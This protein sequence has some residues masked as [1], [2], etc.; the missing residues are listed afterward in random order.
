MLGQRVIAVRV[1]GE[2]EQLIAQNPAGLELQPGQ[3]LE[4][5]SLRASLHRLYATGRYADITAEAVPVA[6]G[7]RI[8][9]RVRDN[10]FVGSVRVEGLREP[11][12]DAQA[13]G[14]LRLSLGETFRQRDLDRG[15]ARLVQLLR[16][17]G[18]YGAVFNPVLA[19]RPE[20]HLVD[21]TVKVETG[22]RARLGPVGASSTPS[23]PASELIHASRLKPGQFLTA[24]RLERGAERARKWLF[25]R[26]FYA[27]R[28]AARAG[29]L[30]AERNMVPV[31]LEITAGSTVKLEVVGVKLSSGKL[32]QLVPVF[33]EGSVDEDLL[34]EGRRN[35]R[36]YYE[37]R[38]Y[39][40]CDVQY[41]ST[42]NP[43]TGA[44]VITYTVTPGARRR[45]VA[46]EF[47]GNKYF[48]DDLLRSQLT[49]HPAEV[50]RSAIFSRRLLQQNE[51]ALRA[52]YVSNGFGSAKVQAEAVEN[53]RGHPEE[54]LARFRIEEGAQTT[55]E[56]LEIA[57][58]SAIA[59]TTLLGVVGS[60]PG[61]PF[62][63]ANV[64]SDRDNILALYLDEGLPETRFESRAFPGSGPGHVRL[65]YEISEG[66]RITVA[67]VLVGGNEHTRM[68]VIRRRI[69]LK[70]EEPLREG[71]VIST[72]RDLYNLGIFSH[73]AVAQ[74]NPQGSETDKT[75]LVNVQEGKRFTVGY[76]AGLE[77][78]PLNNTND[79]TSTT[80]DFAPRG[81]LELTWANFLGRA[82]TVQLR[83]RASTLQGRALLE[84]S[85]PQ[86]LNHR[87]WNLQL[88][89]FADKTRDVRTFTS[90]RYEGSLQLEHRLS[91]ITTLLYR[92]TFRRVLTSDLR[93]AP[94]EIPL[95]SQPTQISGP[96][97]AWVR[98]LR[99]NPANPSRGR[100]Y[101]VDVGL[102]P[103]SLDSTASFLRVFLQN[104]S[105][106]PL[107]HHLVFARSTRF[108]METPFG[109]SL[110]TDIPLAERF[111]AGGG[112]SL[113]GFGLNQ[114]GPRDTTTGFPVGGLTLMTFN[115]ELRFPLRLPYTTAAVT[116]ALFYDA[117]NVYTS[118]RTISLRTTPPPG[119]LNW[120][121][122]SIGFGVHYPTP[123]GPIRIDFGYLL[124]A[125][126][127]QFC[128]NTSA[129][130][131]SVGNPV[132]LGRQRRFQFFLTFGA[133]F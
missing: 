53:Y 74:E 1:V 63:D 130:C 67:Q 85:A 113:R 22:H 47:T 117:G 60:R 11:P 54:L 92:Y 38:G 88:I 107:G 30:D 68:D 13:I 82:Q 48:K 110:S 31:M 119:D 97:V 40:D 123:V 125:P 109:S 27:A 75:M 80:L 69:V 72:Q 16:E 51:D 46:V 15:L 59:T 28:V 21:V 70:P 91:P 3:A 115:Q 83:A 62:S 50:F 26:G 44:R 81:L 8:D 120:L 126:Q 118:L 12:S 73:V 131:P 116:G 128:S 24:A 36:D 122:H 108:G 42:S 33:Q 103:R 20:T 29:D 71:D 10:F 18:F 106:T 98:D 37:R 61:Q 65:A 101:T 127:F 23:F 99:D 14:S 56:S 4:R 19:R 77:V 2:Q 25:H 17:N 86:F 9:F 41:S 5:D 112:A 114:A 121:S 32:K 79:P 96:S 100:F 34:A 45:L 49:I 124:N 133:P 129:A 7:V 66:P 84:Y 55:V 52:L 94:E 93:I 57:G 58:N 87:S 6:G 104:S 111:F 76:G 132:I 105:F 102:F 35:I 39:T 43:D 90:T 64:A 89:G 95:F 78:Q